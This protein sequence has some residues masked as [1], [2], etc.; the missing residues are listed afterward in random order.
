[1]KQSI[2]E[3][4]KGLWD[5]DEDAG[6]DPQERTGRTLRQAIK[7]LEGYSAF[8][9]QRDEALAEVAKLET[10]VAGASTQLDAARA[11]VERLEA[12]LSESLRQ[13]HWAIRVART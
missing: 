1:M 12:S 13:T 4:I 11:E 7:Y 6:S 9:T 2:S 8:Q 3:V 5:I 10:Y